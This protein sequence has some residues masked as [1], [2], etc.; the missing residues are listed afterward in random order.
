[1]P[2]ELMTV[3]SSIG[4]LNSLFFAIYLW[5]QLKKNVKSNKLLAL[6]LLVF[7]FRIGKSVLYYYFRNEMSLY[8][9]TLGLPGMVCIGPLIYLYK[10]L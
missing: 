6:L 1:M 7:S 5:L 9:I 2:D 10:H 3:F 4:V 8:V